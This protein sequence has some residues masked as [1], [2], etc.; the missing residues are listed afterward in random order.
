MSLLNI[1]ADLKLFLDMDYLWV[2]FFSQIGFLSE[3]QIGGYTLEAVMEV[4]SFIS[5][6]LLCFPHWWSKWT[7][8]SL[9]VLGQSPPLKLEQGDDCSRLYKNTTNYP[10][11][12]HHH[13]LLNCLLG[14]SCIKVIW[15]I[16]MGLSDVGPPCYNVHAPDVS[17]GHVRNPISVV[18]M[19]NWS[20]YMV[21]GDS[22]QELAF[23]LS[24]AQGP[25]LG[26]H[27]M[28]PC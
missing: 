24:E 1:I 10:H 28:F 5:I 23:G 9:Y 22:P 19:G 12:P 4:V 14:L 11:S 3:A 6:S 20:S 17:L 26:N 25:F 18:E 8:I 15:V 21:L 16:G 13:D 27:Y 2:Y 7:V